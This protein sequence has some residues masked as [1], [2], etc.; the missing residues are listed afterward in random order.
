MGETGLHNGSMDSVSPTPSSFTTSSRSVIA[1]LFARWRSR[2]LEGLLL[3]A[4]L[5]SLVWFY[6]FAPLFNNGTLSTM[7]WAWQ[8]WN[9]ET[10]YEHAKL[11]PF[12]FLFLLWK[13]AP[14]VD[15]LPARP[16]NLG[17]GLLLG[18]VLLYLVAARSLQPRLALMSLPL[19]LFGA[20]WFLFGWQKSRPLLF[21]VAFLWFMVPLNWIEQATFK[22]QFI[23]TSVASVFCNAV[24]IQ[25]E[26][27]GT[28]L[29]AADG[30]F[31]F[32]IAEGCSGIRSIMAMSMISALYGHYM[33]KVLWKKVALFGA[34][35]LFAIVG[36]VG[37]I[38]TIVL[39][40]KFWD[41]AIASGIY[42][43]YSAFIFFPLALGAMI[44]FNVMLNLHPKQWLDALLKRNEIDS[45]EIQH[46]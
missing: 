23:I 5:L 25:I 2:P 28:T 12:I 4:G 1:S 3:I 36:N 32:E 24:G 43:D 34:S 16:S 41:P 39:V 40:A 6:G 38:V 37:R 26:A 13:S 45:K 11:I 42:H 44:I 30:T 29:L 14:A 9:P 35:V 20:L 22:M 18:G 17:A 19:V 21:P 15:A 10:N 27:V 31:N 33:Q 7:V 46:Y 8:A